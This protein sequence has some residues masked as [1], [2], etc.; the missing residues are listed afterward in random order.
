[1]EKPLLT[2]L[3]FLCM[4]LSLPARPVFY[5]A[6]FAR[7]VTYTVGSI[8]LPNPPDTASPIVTTLVLPVARNVLPMTHS[9]LP[10]AHSVAGQAG[11]LSI[12]PPTRPP[13][14]IPVTI[15]IFN[16]SSGDFSNTFLEW[17]LQVNGVVR[18]KGTI[19]QLIIAP[20]HSGLVRLPATIPSGAGEEAF[21]QIRY[22]SRKKEPPLPAGRII[23]EEQLLLK[24]WDGSNSSVSPVGD[25]SFNDEDGI[26]SIHSAA[27]LMRFD[28]QTGWLQQY[29]VKGFRLLE[30]TP[31]LSPD[32]WRPAGDPAHPRNDTAV[33][34]SL[35]TSSQQATRAPRLQLFS[36]STGSGIVIVRA[37]YLLPETLCHLHLSYTINAAGEMQIEQSMDADSAQKGWTLPRFGMQ[38]ALP[39]GLDSVA[40]YG[41]GTQQKDSNRAAA[42][43]IYRQ[44]ISEQG[45][46]PPASAS[47][48]T[49]ASRNE[50]TAAS[51]PRREPPIATAVRW[52]KITGRDGKGLLITADSALLNISAPS[53]TLLNIDYRPPYDLPYGNYRYAY[54]VTPVIPGP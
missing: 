35:E 50:P 24:A 43:G 37:E 5:T 40:W 14:R 28:K 2:A 16:N 33:S 44:T 48:V 39:P 11:T 20:Q 42:I 36:T 32:F 23:T 51:N 18:Q 13:T 26:F 17:E 46:A 15:R 30:D 47:G 12:R 49:P 9:V 1:M 19:S 52:W 4:H 25:L 10:I 54:K 22:R 38:W 7:P 3:L 53:P 6:A 41:P 34:S 8:I 29:V 45:A 31:G 27:L 21:L